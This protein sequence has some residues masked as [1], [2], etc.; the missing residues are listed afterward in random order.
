MNLKDLEKIIEILKNS[1]VNEFELEQEGTTIRIN[2]GQQTNVV[3][4]VVS[5]QQHSAAPAMNFT[6]PSHS[7]SPTPAP[8]AA[9]S[10][11]DAGLI[12]VESPIVG[13]F[14]RRPSPDADSFVQ[15]GSKVKK[16]DTL[17]IVEAMKLMNEIEATADGVVEKILLDDG[18]IVEYGEVLFLIRP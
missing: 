9:P 7:P 5:S 16:G 12:K 14:Y 17:C 18:H 13:T 2:R 8:I 4:N 6:I 15:V 3:H 11:S 1:D 10:A